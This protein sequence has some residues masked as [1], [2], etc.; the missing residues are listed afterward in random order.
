[1]STPTTPPSASSPAGS[2]TPTPISTGATLDLSDC[3]AQFRR[4]INSSRANLM[5]FSCGKLAVPLDYSKP[6]GTKINLFVV[7]VHSSKQ[8]VADRVGS[9]LVNPGGPGGSGINLAAGLVDGLSDQ[10]FDHFDLVGFDPR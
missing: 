3:T 6:T 5:E 7:R 8:R 10:I 1:T 4:A 2:A 9:L